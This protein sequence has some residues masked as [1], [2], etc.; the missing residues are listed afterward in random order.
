MGSDGSVIIICVLGEDYGRESET[1]L[2]EVA[3]AY[4]GDRAATLH[5]PFVINAIYYPMHKIL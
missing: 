4:D 2:G 3:K 5:N 1:A